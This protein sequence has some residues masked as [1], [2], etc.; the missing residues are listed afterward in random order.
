MVALV[1][2]AAASAQDGPTTSTESTS[3]TVPATEQ[4]VFGTLLSDREPVIGA[5]ITVN[6]PDGVEIATVETLDDGTWA[7]PLDE[8]GD[9]EVS[10]DTDSLP[11]GTVLTRDDLQTQTKSVGAGRAAAVLFPLGSGG[12][13]GVAEGG[14]AGSSTFDRVSQRLFDGVKFGLIIAM[15]AIGLSLVFGTTGLINFAHGELVTFGAIVAWFLNTSGP[16]LHL[17]P[18]AILAALATGLLG[19]AIQRGI[20]QPL[21]PKHLGSFQKLILTIG[22]AL[23][24]RHILLIWFG[25]R[26]RSYIQYN[27]QTEISLGPIDAT[28]RDL[29]VM[30]IAVATLVAVA[31]VL[32][33][34]RVGKAMRAVS[35]NIDLAESS[36]IN[37]QRIVLYVW[38]AGAALAAVGGVMFGAIEAVNYQMG[39]RLLLLMFAGVILGG[40]GTAYGAMVGSL[41]VGIAAELS[42]LVFSPELRVA[43]AL[44]LLIF[45]LLVKPE[46]LLGTRERIG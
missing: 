29:A 17:V 15:T 2:S 41:V 21:Q 35:D 24:I 3:T 7:V 12:E 34:T 1:P 33:Y 39:F 10:L 18:A 19:G 38:I 4:G 31:S 5:S 30:T 44:G 6:G 8:P 9:Y 32:K 26:S 28:P 11:D 14:R 20:F 16:R 25:G 42:T 22:L 13:D 36:G 40:L 46:G 27:V 43:V 37:V 23:V 45:A